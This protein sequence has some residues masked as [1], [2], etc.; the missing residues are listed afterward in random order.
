MIKEYLEQLGINPD[1]PTLKGTPER[2]TRMFKELIGN[3]GSKPPEMKMFTAAATGEMVVVRNIKAATLCPHHLLPYSLT[4]DFAYVPKDKT[5]VGISKPARLFEWCCQRLTMQ[6]EI[7]TVFI[8]TFS[9]FV[10][11]QGCILVIEGIH[12]CTVIRGAK[13]AESSTITFDSN[14]VFKTDDRL[15]KEFWQLAKRG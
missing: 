12:L 6:E 4:A 10:P 3:N 5:V 7:A 1:D 15:R 9:H 2:V 14:G 11:S 13:Q 8:E